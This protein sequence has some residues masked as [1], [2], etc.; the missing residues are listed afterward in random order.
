M[1]LPDQFEQRT[2]NLLFTIGIEMPKYVTLQ[3]KRISNAES[4]YRESLRH[5]GPDRKICG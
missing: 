1:R 2:T 5:V 3:D 4:G